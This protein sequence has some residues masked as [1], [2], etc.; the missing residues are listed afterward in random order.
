MR[1][2]AFVRELLDSD[3]LAGYVLAAALRSRE[4]L[5]WWGSPLS[6]SLTRH[7]SLT[8]GED[9]VRGAIAAVNAM[10][11]DREL[12]SAVQKWIEDDRVA[13]DPWIR[14]VAQRR[15][16]ALVDP[17]DYCSGEPA[18]TWDEI[19][20]DSGIS[21]AFDLR[22]LT[23]S[24]ALPDVDVLLGG[25]CGHR[26]RCDVIDVGGG[27]GQYTVQLLASLG[28]RATATLIDTYA[29]AGW[30][31]RDAH[32]EL[33]KRVDIQ[34]RDPMA[35]LPAGCDLYFLGSL[36]HDLSDTLASNLVERCACAGVAGSAI[37]IVERDWDPRSLSDSGRDLDMQLLFGGRE[38]TDD[39]LSRLLT[40]S[41]FEVVRASRMNGYRVLSGRLATAGN[42]ETN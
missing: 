39:E 35:A 10:R 1:D 9:D 31:V 37:V 41:G 30:Y 4:L 17:G 14:Y 8:V 26:G 7:L 11:S 24:A 42:R 32:P 23:R 5:P 2:V 15:Y 28:P 20:R 21:R 6:E 3:P 25:A 40:V 19:R 33:A 29:D 18:E 16:A 36:L 34:Q 12:T 13:E 22:M 27:P 38:R